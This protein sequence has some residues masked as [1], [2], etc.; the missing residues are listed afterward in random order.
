MGVTNWMSSRSWLLA[1]L[2]MVLLLTVLGIA[3]EPGAEITYVNNTDKVL[4]VDA[5]SMGAL[6]VEPHSQIEVSEF[7]FGKDD[8]FVVTVRDEAGN[9][10]YYEETTL[11]ELKERNYTVII[12]EPDPANQ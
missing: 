5:D 11:R 9:I 2:G 10:V 12:E 6:R 3:C 1:A 8:P 7:P 4:F